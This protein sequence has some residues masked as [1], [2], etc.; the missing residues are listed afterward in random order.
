MKTVNKANVLAG[1]PPE[2]PIDLMS[3]IETLVNQANVKIVVLDDDPTGNQTVHNVVVLTEWSIPSLCAVF[4]ASDPVV[5]VLT[6]SRSVS[7]QQAQVLNREIARNLLAAR[8][9]SGR[10]FVVVSRSDST[11]RGHYPGEVDAL[12]NALGELFDGSLIIP[13]EHPG[14]GLPHRGGSQ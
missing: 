1:L 6:N 5:F 2:W 9:I 12:A 8:R 13:Q 14:F 7:L 4:E 11:L 10:N 3:E